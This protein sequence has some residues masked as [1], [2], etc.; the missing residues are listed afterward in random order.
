MKKILRGL[1]SITVILSIIITSAIVASAA[2]V[3][4]SKTKIDTYPEKTITLKLMNTSKKVKWYTEDEELATVKSTGKNTAKVRTVAPGVVNIKAKVNGRI[5]KCKVSISWVENKG[6][7]RYEYYETSYVEKDHT[8]NYTFNKKGSTIN[9]IYCGYKGDL[10]VSSSNEN[11]AKVEIINKNRVSITGKTGGKAEIIIQF[12]MHKHIVNVCLYGNT[13]DLI[14]YIN[15]YG[16]NNE[17]GEKVINGTVKLYSGFYYPYDITYNQKENYIKMIVCPHNDEAII[18]IPLYQQGKTYKSKSTIS[19]S[20]KYSDTKG[21]GVG[22][23]TVYT[24]REN[25]RNVQFDNYTGSLD[26]EKFQTY[27]NGTLSYF[28]KMTLDIPCY[29]QF[30]TIFMR[31]GE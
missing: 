11:V 13:T 10:S 27:W 14:N 15:E 21:F 5:Y 7:N 4:L 12:G 22:T 31:T 1:L 9:Y 16:T 25:L 19:V 26:I 20:F 6:N 24:P 3:K 18:K 2:T 23:G 17:E 29:V 28:R 30:D 8:S